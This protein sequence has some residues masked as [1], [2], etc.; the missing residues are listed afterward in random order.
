METHGYLFRL[1]VK[2]KSKIIHK[3]NKQTKNIVKYEICF[4]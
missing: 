1:L 4:L 3:Q 2:T